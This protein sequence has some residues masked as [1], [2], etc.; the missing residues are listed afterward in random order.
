MKFLDGEARI[1]LL[2]LHVRF[3]NAD[4]QFML[5]LEN[6]SDSDI[7][8]RRHATTSGSGVRSRCA[9]SVITLVGHLQVRDHGREILLQVLYVWALFNLSPSSLRS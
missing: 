3:T 8:N 5:L 7:F 1:R 4:I 2:L 9:N 6:V